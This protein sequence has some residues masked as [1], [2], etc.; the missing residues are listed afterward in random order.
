MMSMFSSPFSWAF[1]LYR[2]KL[3]CF[4]TTHF[5]LDTADSCLFPYFFFCVHPNNLM[6]SPHF[7]PEIKEVDGL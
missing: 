4:D 6:V 3:D 7:L 1:T 2:K 5:S